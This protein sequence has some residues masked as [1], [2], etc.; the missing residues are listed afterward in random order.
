MSKLLI[1]VQVAIVVFAVVYLG[2]TIYVL[3]HFVTK[4]W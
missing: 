3:Y 4:F 2:T 1:A